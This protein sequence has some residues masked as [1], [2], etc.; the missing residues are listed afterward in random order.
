MFIK[1]LNH[2]QSSRGFLAKTWG[3]GKFMASKIDSIIRQGMNIYGAV[4][5][6]AQEIAGAYGGAKARQALTNIDQGVSKAS[7]R[8]QGARDKAAQGGALVEKLSG[9]IGG[10]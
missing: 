3:H 8:Y 4:K 6:V 10:Y 9:A 5:P 2:L 7:Q 1:Q